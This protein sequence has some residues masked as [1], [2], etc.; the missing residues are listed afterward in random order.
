MDKTSNGLSL[1][2]LVF[3]ILFILKLCGVLTC[4]W[5]IVT[6]PL[7]IVPAITFSIIGVALGVALIGGILCLIGYLI[8]LLYEKLF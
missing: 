2:T 5:W 1:F 8:M 7:W 4:S 6:M 3:I